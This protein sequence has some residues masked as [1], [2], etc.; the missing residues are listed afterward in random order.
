MT[1]PASARQL[2][3]A[4]R[5]Q[6]ERPVDLRAR[7]MKGAAHVE[8][9]VVQRASWR[10][11]PCVP[12]GQPPTSTT[13]PPGRAAATACSQASARPTASKTR[14]CSPSSEAERAPSAS[15]WA[16]RSGWRSQHE[17]VAALE[18]EQPREHQ[19]DRPAAEDGGVRARRCRARRRARRRRAARPSRRRRSPGH[20]GSRAARAGG[21]AMRSAKPPSTHVGARQI[22]ARPARQGPHSPQATESPTSTRS[23]VSARTPAVSW[24]NR[25]G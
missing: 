11:T 20:R 9:V 8:L 4:G 17:H 7:V 24:P 5:Q 16:R 19:P 10:A 14:S 13:V 25:A 18:H 2:D 3:V 23:P 15:A 12:D 6:R 1:S 22:A 21:A